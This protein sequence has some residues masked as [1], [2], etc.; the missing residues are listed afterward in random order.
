MKLSKGLIQVYTGSGKGKT[1]AALGQAVRAAG[2][3]LKVYIVQFL[4]SDDTGELISLKKLYPEIQI[5]RFEK[6]RGF[7]WTLNDSERLELKEEIKTAFEFCIKAS[8]NLECDVL[9]MD[10]IMGVLKNK[11]LSINE[12]VE[13]VKNKPLNLEIVMTGRDVPE[14]IA[15]VADLITEMREIKHYFKDGI[16]ARKGIEY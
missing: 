14:E 3:G 7:F 9:I 1:T 4:K 6:P 13:F 12:V 11:L 5:F 16:P 2:S 8:L 15:N 10:E